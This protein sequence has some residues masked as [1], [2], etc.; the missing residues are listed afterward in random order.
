MI[1]HTEKQKL[2]CF[3]KK[4]T[5][6]HTHCTVVMNSAEMRAAANFAIVL[7]K[8]GRD[9]M[10]PNNIGVSSAQMDVKVVFLGV[11]Y[12]GKTSLIDRFLNNR[13]AGEDRY[14]VNN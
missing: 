6:K 12:C 8:F 13:F 2:T 9:K 10:L 5:N 7:D 1:S 14:Q 11:E 3:I 4:D